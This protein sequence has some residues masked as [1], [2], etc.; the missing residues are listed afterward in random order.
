MQGDVT[1]AACSN[2]GEPTSPYQSAHRMCSRS[3]RNIAITYLTVSQYCDTVKVDS[4]RGRNA[5]PHTI[6]VFFCEGNGACPV[7]LWLDG[8]IAKVQDKCIV[9]IERL[10]ELGHE[11]RRPEADFLRDGIYELRASHQSVNYRMLYFFHQQTAVLSHGLTKE[12]EVPGREIDR[13]LRNKG[14]FESNP[15]KYTYQDDESHE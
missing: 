5:M 10:A 1:L 12:K 14:L 3:D 7:L 11:L 4:G 6:V 2:G 8:L 13:A 9:K 15:T